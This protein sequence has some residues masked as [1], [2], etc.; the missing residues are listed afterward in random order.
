MFGGHRMR[1][2]LRYSCKEPHLWHVADPGLLNALLN[3]FIINGS[4]PPRGNLITFKLFWNFKLLCGKLSGLRS[5]HTAFLTAR[6]VPIPTDTLCNW[7]ETWTLINL[8][9]PRLVQSNS[10]VTCHMDL[11][12]LIKFRWRIPDT[13]DLLWRQKDVRLS[14]PS[15]VNMNTATDQSYLRNG[16]NWDNW[17]AS[18]LTKTECLSNYAV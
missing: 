18:G 13:I 12:W 15:H 3:E 11:N 7:P 16:K 5:M 10:N 1:N 6:E 4:I 14:S 17:D 8:T 2:V 9:Y